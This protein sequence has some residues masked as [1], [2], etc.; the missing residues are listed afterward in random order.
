MQRRRNTTPPR[1]AFVTTVAVAA[2][3]TTLASACNVDPSV[4]SNPPPV[5]TSVCPETSP[6]DGD[7]CRW[8]VDGL[9]CYYGP[10][11]D[12]QRATCD[13]SRGWKVE[14]NFGS[15]NPP[16]PMP[17]PKSLPKTGDDCS[18]GGFETI[19]EGCSYT[20]NTSCG[21]KKVTPS[22]TPVEAGASPT[23]VWVVEA[24]DCS[25]EPAACEDYEHP[26]L[27]VADS[28]CRYLRPGCA[29][30]LQQPV[31]EGCYPAN[32]C[33]ESSCDTNESCTTV[34]NDPCPGLIPGEPVC[35][36]CGSEVSVCLP[37]M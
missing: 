6:K 3:V 16:V 22:C 34:V 20:V 21:E 2:S 10:D 25:G 7:D 26:D 8:F 19:P 5:P 18:P 27:C 29:D 13:Q 17:C 31:P 4:T 24:P 28:A 14:E 1:S 33:E 37:V 30:G 9:E 32:D 36:A 35:G 12:E 23:H 11:C 15:C